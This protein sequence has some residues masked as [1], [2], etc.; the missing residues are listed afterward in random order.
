MHKT[1]HFYLQ[2]QNHPMGGEHPYPNPIPS[3]PQATRSPALFGLKSLSERAWL[4]CCWS[5]SPEGERSVPAAQGD[6]RGRRMIV[7]GVHD[8]A[9]FS[10][11]KTYRK[12]AAACTS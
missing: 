12:E 3:W 7:N 10:R 5:D 11:W 1:L 6:L 8:S 2:I 4:N 9:A